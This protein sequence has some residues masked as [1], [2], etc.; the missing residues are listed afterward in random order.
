[1]SYSFIDLFCGAGGFSLGFRQA[2]YKPILGIDI[3]ESC[4]QSY[5]YN[6]PDTMVIKED[7]R[8]IHSLDILKL[9]RTDRPKVIIASPPCEAFTRISKAIMK[10]PLDRLYTDPRGRL[11]LDAIRIIGD[12][13][14]EIFVVENVPG[15]AEPIIRDNIKREFERYGYNKIYFN[16]IDAEVLGVPSMRRRVFISN[17]QIKTPGGRERINVWDAIKDLPDPKYPS[18]IPNHEYVDI[19]LRFRDRIWR[20]GWGEGLEYFMGGNLKVYLEYVR[21]HPFKPAPVVMGRSRFIH[22]FE[23][24]LLTVREQA[25]LMTYPDNFTFFGNKNE[26]YNQ[27]GESVPPALAKYIG[28]AIMDL[29]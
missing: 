10:D 17:V 22:P 1:M 21:L 4:I 27:V 5:K 7:I 9:I 23:N 3:N 14:P 28:E 15:I 6:F 29:I 26:Q 13:N 2:G 11:T 25:R 19:P 20:L 24:R 8:S 12:I 16:I 18:T